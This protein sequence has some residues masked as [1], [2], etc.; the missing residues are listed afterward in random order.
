MQKKFSIQ[1][2]TRK[3]ISL[4]DVTTPP[5]K[6]FADDEFVLLFPSEAASGVI[7]DW[8][9]SAYSSR[10]FVIDGSEVRIGVSIGPLGRLA[11]SAALGFAFRIG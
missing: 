1:D 11:I 2:A 5:L 3:Y 9:R 4:H 7:C 8:S 10:P 6:R